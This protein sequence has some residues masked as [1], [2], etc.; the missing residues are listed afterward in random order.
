MQHTLYRNFP[1]YQ[2]N[3]CYIDTLLIMLFRSTDIMDPFFFNLNMSKRMH[4]KQKMCVINHDIVN[5]NVSL[6]TFPRALTF[7][8]FEHFDKLR[9]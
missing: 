7:S 5:Q 3:N 1:T 9:V 6:C 8:I 2:N 4:Y